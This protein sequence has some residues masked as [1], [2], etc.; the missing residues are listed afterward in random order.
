VQA[1]DVVPG[2][3]HPLWAYLLRLNRA[4][5]TPNGKLNFLGLVKGLPVRRY[6]PLEG[7]PGAVFV[8]A[9]GSVVTLRPHTDALPAQLAEQAGSLG[10]SVAEHTHD[11]QPTS[12]AA[13]R[14]ERAV[15]ATELSKGS[16][17]A[18]EQQ[19]AE[20]VREHND[21]SIYFTELLGAPVIVWTDGEGRYQVSGTLNNEQ[22]SFA[23]MLLN[24]L[25]DD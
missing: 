7:K 2:P 5:Y 10:L 17:A 8:S 4:M 22:R 15:G 1:G 11:A 14:T 23:L 18:R 9:Q 3:D 25:F 19:G 13:R 12:Q 6:R 20:A 16:M 21:L 24:G